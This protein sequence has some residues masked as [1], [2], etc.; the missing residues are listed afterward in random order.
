V[1]DTADDGFESIEVHVPVATADEQREAFEKYLEGKPDEFVAFARRYKP[2]TFFKLAS[3]AVLYVVG[4]G[5]N[6]SSLDVSPINPA[7]DYD[8]ALNNLQSVELRINPA[9]LH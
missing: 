1:N 7:V 4:Y 2:G 6:G 9:G 5:E 3:G 8:A